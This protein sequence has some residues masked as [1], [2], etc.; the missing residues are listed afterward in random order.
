[1][2]AL[3]RVLAGLSLATVLVVAIGAAG[4]GL[5]AAHVQH[6]HA[7]EQAEPMDPQAH[8][9]AMAEHLSLTPTQQETLAEPFL[10][11]FAAMEEL[12]RLHDVIAAE[13]TDEQRH[14][15]AEMIHG[16]L[17]AGMGERH[18]QSDHDGSRHH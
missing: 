10:A 5:V 11:A 18:A 15:L 3:H 6:G 13:L 1:M 7:A 2:R 16:M 8:F 14:Q 12:H 4:T 9:E 17:G